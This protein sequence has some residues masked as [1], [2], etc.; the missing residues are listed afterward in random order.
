VKD[1]VAHWGFWHL[2]RFSAE[3]RALFGELPSDTLK[4]A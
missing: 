1:V 4:R 3:Y 2:S